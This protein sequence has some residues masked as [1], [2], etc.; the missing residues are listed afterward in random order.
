MHKFEI[1]KRVLPSLGPIIFRN[2]FILVNA[3]IFSVVTLLFIFGNFEAGLFLVIILFL[4]TFISVAQDIHAR[5][6]LEKLQML[7]A[8]SV[9]RLNKDETETLILA[10]KIKKGDLIKLKLGDQA[11]C[12]GI[13][14]SA[15]NLEIS[16][17]L[18]TGESDSFSK[19][20]GD[21]VI[22]GAIITSGYGIMEAQELFRE[23]RLSII[24]KD[25]KKYASNPSSI[26]QA[27]NKIITYSGY[28][29]LAVLLFVFIR[30]TL[31]HASKLEMVMNAG[32]LASLLVP[33][34]LIVVITLLFAIGAANYAKR[35]V[36]FQ[37]INATEKLGRIKNLC[38][39]K[40]GTLTDNILVVE[41]MYVPKDFKEVDAYALTR[42]CIF[43]LGDSSQTVLAVKKYLE[44]NKIN[45]EGG[46]AVTK[47]LSFS[48]WRRY[49]AIEIKEKET[50]RSIFIGTPDIFLPQIS[51]Q[52]E[53]KW[54]EGI[55]E[56]NA[57][58]GKRVLCVTQSNKI[59][60]LKNIEKVPLSVVAI[61]VFHNTLR[62]GIEK[63]I[64]FF[65]DRGIKIRVLSGDNA[66]TVRAVT[67]S[68]GINGAESVITGEEMEKWNDIDFEIN[69]HKYTVFAQVLPEHKVKLIT[70]FKK[71]GFT[72]MVGD[73]VNDA[74]AMKKSDLS[75]AMFD[76]VPVTRQLAD[77]ILM[78]N[79]FSDLP[80]AVELA[81]H[82]IRSIEINSGLYI[83]QSL[84]GLFFFIIISLFGFAFPLTP[85]NIT[86]MN[87][88][89]I[90]FAGILIYYWALRPTGKILPANDKPFLKRI[91]PLVIYCAIVEAIGISI[92][93][94]L[95]PYYLKIASSNTLVGLSF[96]LFGFL[97]LIFAIKV[98]CGS[99]TKKEKLQLFLL[100]IFELIVFYLMLQ[101]PFFIRFFN[102]T[103][104]YPTFTYIY[105]TFAIFIIFG[106]IQYLIIK[107][108]FLK[109][110]KGI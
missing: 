64:R 36:L 23:S 17:A 44:K 33:Q 49:G 56:E 95:S 32:A 76:G 31:I 60:V 42:A 11:P 98:Y 61:F 26:Q 55:I 51:N 39:D 91:M 43:G 82:F 78:T 6:L 9:L 74:L 24:S 109:N 73:G 92:V 40:T 65:Q 66:E 20:R 53:K 29:L 87:Y 30:G 67:K 12:E 77:V 108:L 27:N 94:A 62:Q 57:L 88:F 100:A 35:D 72:A 28:I 46:I 14:L 90:G 93:F 34:G 15:E 85:L 97:F 63:T 71:D 75:I 99:I 2:I 19:I 41:N 89:T 13:L 84:V 102:I 80:G 47:T 5:I 10:E 86:F 59:E 68:V 16:E 38:I 81:D 37:E 45:D 110:K 83:N 18:I 107:K 101:V 69:A 79:S 21:K 50:F 8:L 25:I 7:T 4:N 70:A 106:F 54:L 105:K 48:S 103:L 3:I 52:A 104:P 22:A 96:I 1:Y 58:T